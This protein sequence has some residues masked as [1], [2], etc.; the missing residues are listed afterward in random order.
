MQN[1]LNFYKKLGDTPLTCIER[2]RA[3]HPEYNGVALSYAGRLDP[4]AEGVLLVLVGEENKRREEYL[5]LPKVYEVQVLFGFATDT[6]DIL[7]LVT[8]RPNMWKGSEEEFQDTIS[9]TLPQ[10]L[11]KFMQQYPPY[12]SKPVQGKPLFQWAREGKLY[13]IQ[14]PSHEVEVYNI[15]LLTM[16]NITGEAL[17]ELIS[18]QISSV[19]GDFRQEEIVKSWQK[20]LAT[21]RDENFPVVT[22]R[23]ECS[24][25]TYVRGIAHE[26]GKLLGTNA[27]AF[28]I[29]RTQVG[30]FNLKSIEYR[31]KIII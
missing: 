15:E 30:E 2:F 22:L 13:E 23:I 11:G 20:I 18:Q 17:E 29:L 31:S 14:I 21:C 7:G 26:L 27:I 3:E 12:S 16:Q 19:E 8:A 25:G 9:K 6:Y 24:S 10:F 28:H 1:V 4:M 5:K